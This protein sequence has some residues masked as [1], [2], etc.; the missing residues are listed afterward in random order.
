MAAQ[1]CC[2]A[3]QLQAWAKST[4][5]IDRDHA[6]QTK[7]VVAAG[8][9]GLGFAVMALTNPAVEPAA[10]PQDRDVQAGEAAP[11]RV[12]PGAQPRGQLLYENHCMA[13]HESVVHIRSRQGARSLSELQA[14]VDHWARYMKLP[15]STEEVVDVTRFLDSR[16]YRFE[17]RP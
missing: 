14:K 15:W 7:F 2:A 3:I 6:M 4:P 16:Y 8:L 13:C 1:A 5:P 9:L 11:Q 17:S 10:V 12:E